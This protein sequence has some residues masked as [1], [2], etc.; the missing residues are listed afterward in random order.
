[1]DY[2]D[3]KPFSDMLSSI[4]ES[5]KITEEQLIEKCNK[6]NESDNKK[7]AHSFLG[8]S[9]KRLPRKNHFTGVVINAINLILLENVGVLSNII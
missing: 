2:R 8:N 9:F 3:L 4:N 5:Y 1:M 6:I 7:I